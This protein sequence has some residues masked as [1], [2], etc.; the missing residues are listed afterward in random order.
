MHCIAGAL[1]YHIQP[2]LIIRIRAGIDIFSNGW[3]A[4]KIGGVRI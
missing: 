3:S 1:L 4:G 2:Q